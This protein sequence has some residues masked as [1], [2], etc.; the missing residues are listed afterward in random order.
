MSSSVY[1]LLTLALYAVGALHVFLHAMSRSRLLTSWT[2]T[3]TLGGFVVHTAGLSQRWTEAGHF[4]AVGLRD[5]SS[6][7][8]WAIV[9]AFLMT[10]VRTREAVLSLAV[11]PVAFSLVLVANLTPA[12]ASADPILKSL[13]LPVHATLAFF[14]YGSLFVACAMGVL[15][16]VQ[17]RELKSRSP[18]AFYYLAPSLERCDTLTARSLEVGFTFLT[19]AILT[20][21]LWSHSAR[22]RYWSGDPKEWSAVVAWLI[23][24][25]LI[26][27]RTRTGWGGRRSALLGIAAFVAVAFTFL[28]MT[29]LAGAANAVR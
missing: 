23:Y 18:R 28:W 27:A 8:A 19:L 6:F 7:L 11:H 24:V 16:L 15:Y 10:Y 9:L 1:L 25:G 2:V 13:Y 21:L 12:S 29:V 26:V 5:G 4:P 3:A 17:E 22:G 14:G 20:G